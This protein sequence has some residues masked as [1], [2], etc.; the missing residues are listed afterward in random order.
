VAFCV[1]HVLP[2]P[3]EGG[4][5]LTGRDDI[6]L[7]CHDTGDESDVDAWTDE[8]GQVVRVSVCEENPL[9]ASLPAVG[10]APPAVCLDTPRLRRNPESSREIGKTQSE[11]IWEMLG[12][13][14]F[15]GPS[16]YEPHYTMPLLHETF[17]KQCKSGLFTANVVCHHIISSATYEAQVT[18]LDRHAAVLCGM[19]SLLPAV[20]PACLQATDI[21]GQS[22]VVQTRWHFLAVVV[23]AVAVW[24]TCTLHLW[25]CARTIFTYHVHYTIVSSLTALLRHD[26]KDRFSLPKLD[27]AFPEHVVAWCTHIDPVG[28]FSTTGPLTRF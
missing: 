5:G 27:M 26:E 1:S 3:R 15:R 13:Y 9:E 21:W 4:F 2:I 8:T 17:I 12:H 11:G 23:Q 16:G 22:D 18:F 25:I 24:L 14:H 6:D 10:S 28:I 7:V 19:C 20:A